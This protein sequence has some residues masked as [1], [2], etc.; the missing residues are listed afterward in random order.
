MHGNTIHSISNK[1]YPAPLVLYQQTPSLDVNWGNNR[2][3]TTSSALWH[4]GTSLLL[5]AAP[6]C[7]REDA[8]H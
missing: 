5:F 8:A 3:V 4:R 2:H 7:F 1:K 6:Q